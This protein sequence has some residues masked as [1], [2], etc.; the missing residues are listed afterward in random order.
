MCRCNCRKVTFCSENRVEI[1]FSYKFSLSEA[2]RKIPIL[3]KMISDHQKPLRNEMRVQ[4]DRWG[5]L[6][7]QFSVLGGLGF[8]LGQLLGQHL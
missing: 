1:E 6:K 8:G 3:N 7:I 4:N 2:R 5:V